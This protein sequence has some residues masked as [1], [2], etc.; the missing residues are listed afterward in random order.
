ME[1][2]TNQELYRTINAISDEYKAADQCINQIYL[3]LRK[4]AFTIE[5]TDV[6][7]DAVLG[8]ME[9]CEMNIRAILLHNRDYSKPASLDDQAHVAS[10]GA[11]YA[12]A[13]NFLLD[14][15]ARV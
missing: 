6:V 1:T 4:K 11:S 3:Q 12:L 2:I 15:K 13:I 8:W 10:Y 9:N 7:R 5:Q 14:L